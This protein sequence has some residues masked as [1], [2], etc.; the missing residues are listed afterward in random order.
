MMFDV[1]CLFGREEF[2]VTQI[3]GACGI[4]SPSITCQV[5]KSSVFDGKVCRAKDVLLVN[6]SSPALT[7]S[8]Q[9]SMR[10]NSTVMGVVG[11]HCESNAIS[12]WCSCIGRI[13]P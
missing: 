6:G 7:N 4:V 10:V 3:F 8:L 13:V 5:E 2:E 12:F 9:S 1:G 11:Y